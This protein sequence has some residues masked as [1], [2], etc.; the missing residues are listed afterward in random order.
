MNEVQGYNNVG[1]P[2]ADWNYHQQ[3]KAYVDGGLV[4]SKFIDDVSGIVN[5]GCP[6]ATCPV[7]GAVDGLAK[8]KENFVKVLNALGL[9]PK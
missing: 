2:Y 3:L 5:R 8:R 1:G 4:G 9:D 6:D 7:S